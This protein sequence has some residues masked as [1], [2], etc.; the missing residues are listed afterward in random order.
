VNALVRPYTVALYAI[1]ALTTPRGAAHN[2]NYRSE[3]A[4]I[5]PG[6]FASPIKL[7]RLEFGSS[8][9]DREH[10]VELAHEQYAGSAA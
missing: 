2:W 8:F 6:K 3:R 7:A 9:Y 10:H 4:K 5:V 1:A